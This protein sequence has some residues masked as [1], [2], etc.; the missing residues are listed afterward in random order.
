VLAHVF[1]QAG[2]ILA[3]QS[4]DRAASA[5]CLRSSRWLSQQLQQPDE[6][7]GA[8]RADTQMRGHAWKAPLRITGEHALSKP[9]Q[10]REGLRAPRIHWVNGQKSR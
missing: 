8:R 3:N 4:A 10:H 9:I 2:D 1:D 7:L 6:V 5:S